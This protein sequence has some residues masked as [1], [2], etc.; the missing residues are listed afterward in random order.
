MKTISSSDVI[1]KPSY[2]T[3]PQEITI[4]KD[5]K[6]QIIKSVVLPYKLYEKIR[7]KIEDEIYL[8]ENK[9]ALSNSAYEEF[10]EIE[11]V[12]EELAR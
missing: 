8:L 11:N 7:E 2:I 6:K 9:D 5:T 4:V 1:K 10:L 3:N 12:C